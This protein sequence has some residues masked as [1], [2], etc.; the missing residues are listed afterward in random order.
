M[1]ACKAEASFSSSESISSNLLWRGVL[2]GL[3][4]S[5]AGHTAF[6]APGIPGA[7][8]YSRIASQRGYSC[9]ST[10]A[11]HTHLI[12]ADSLIYVSLAIWR[13]LHQQT[14]H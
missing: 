10:D 5:I 7:T 1:S 12:K 4:T 11:F 9:V 14:A 13:K 8:L 2:G 3:P 6:S